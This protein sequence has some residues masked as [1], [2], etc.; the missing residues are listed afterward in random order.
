MGGAATSAFQLRPSLGVAIDV[1]FASG[2]GSPSHKTF[3]LG[4]G[5]TLMWGPNIHPMLHKTFKELADRLEIPYAVE[6]VPRHTGT[7]AMFMQIAGEGIP[8][9]ALGIPLRY[10]HTPVEM[11]SLKDINRAGRLL[12]EFIAEL[13]GEFM[14]KL[15]W[16]D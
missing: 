7:D 4:K 8:C 10:M 9:I 16:E 3:P 6:A 14:G 13:D 2:P 5:P 11:V 15:V 1:I 12:A